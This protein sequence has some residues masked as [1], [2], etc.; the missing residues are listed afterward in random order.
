M[1]G[2]EE[3]TMVLRGPPGV[4]VSLL[5]LLLPRVRPSPG[6]IDAGR[7]RGRVQLRLLRRRRITGS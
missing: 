3:D 5:L 4:W 6:R 1:L 7:A 2:V